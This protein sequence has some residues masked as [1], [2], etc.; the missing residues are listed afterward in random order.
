VGTAY[1]RDGLDGSVRV[2]GYGGPLIVG[3]S[4]MR[5]NP[6]MPLR[7]ATGRQAFTGVDVRYA[8]SRGVQLRGEL[9]KGRSFDGVSTTGWYLDGMLHRPVMGPF[10]AV[11]RG[12]SLDYTA[13][14]P[15]ARA[16]SRFTIGTKVRLPWRLTTQIN[17]MHQNGDLPRIYDSSLDF[18]VTYSVRYR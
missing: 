7:F 4:Y 15:R 11:V 12:E 8:S 9:L 17:Y 5:S 1:R 14:P 10:T 13:A 18:S 6:Y 2:Q 3:V 16:A